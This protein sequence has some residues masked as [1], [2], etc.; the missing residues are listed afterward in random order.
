MLKAT[1]NKKNFP[2]A[3]PSREHNAAIAK[4]FVGPVSYVDRK[5]ARHRGGPFDISVRTQIATP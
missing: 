5:K 1:M 4:W 3:V 2:T